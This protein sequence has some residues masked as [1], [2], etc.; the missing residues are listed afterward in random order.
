MGSHS[1]P[2]PK[3]PCLNTTYAYDTTVAC[4]R[5]WGHEPLTRTQKRGDHGFTWGDNDCSEKPVP[6]DGP[7]FGVIETKGFMAG[8]HVIEIGDAP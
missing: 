3:Q 7:V 4:G 6:G 2:E 1:K 8:G 5:P